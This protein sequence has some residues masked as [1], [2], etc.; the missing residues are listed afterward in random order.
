MLRDVSFL[1]RFHIMS[2]G[3]LFLMAAAP[4]AAVAAPCGSGPAGFNA[5]LQH[6]RAR[7]AAKGISRSTISSALSDVS[8][9]RKVVR[10]DNS[11]HSFKLSF[12]RF[13]AL[14]VNEALIS[15]GR[16]LMR[17]HRRTLDRIESRFGVPGAVLVAIWGL[18]THYGANLG[19]RYSIIQSLA[20]LAYDCRRPQFFEGQLLDALRIV[21]RG[22]LSA[23][24]LRGGWAG[25]I[26]QTQ[27][28]PTAYYRYAVDFDGN[29]HRDL[30]HSVA[31]ALASTA[32]FLASHGWQRGQSW[33]PGSHNYGVI[34]EWN[35]AD[36]YQRTIAVMAD[37][38]SGRG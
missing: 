34:A 29:G 28:L 1:R 24:Q 8:Y 6:F 23:R 31:D 20:T 18:E 32:N 5:W 3:A 27:F 30:V 12:Q 7:A 16:S 13:Y 36:V 35:K 38:L 17:K 11:Q 15:R 25:E 14:R 37:K 4:A 10:L 19:A 33:E 21:D 22:D 26:G 9:D 2:V